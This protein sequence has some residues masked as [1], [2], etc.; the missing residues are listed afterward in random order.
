MDHGIVST[1]LRVIQQYGLAT[2]LVAVA[3]LVGV[4]VAMRFA[5]AR[6]EAARADQAAA[7]ER[8]ARE[9]TAALEAQRAALERERVAQVARDAAQAKLVQELEAARLQNLTIMTNHLAHDSDERE[10][11]VRALAKADSRDEAMVAALNEL[12]A[13]IREDRAAA[14]SERKAFH[15]RLNAIH[16]D[17]RS[18]PGGTG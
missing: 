2:A 6:I 11:V 15:E 18:R 7:L 3:L 4:F 5:L 10:A 13:S 12:A 14:T 8:Q 9:Q 1:F 16:L 17:V